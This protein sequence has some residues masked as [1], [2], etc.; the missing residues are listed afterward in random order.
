MKLRM[1]S[2]T[3]RLVAVAV[4]RLVLHSSFL[5]Q[6]IV[7]RHSDLVDV[8]ALN[9]KLFDDVNQRIRQVVEHH[10]LQ[11]GLRVH[12]WMKQLNILL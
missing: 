3:G 9:L 11:V 8:I 4:A 2:A 7:G 12:R 6:K 5:L 10:M 1:M